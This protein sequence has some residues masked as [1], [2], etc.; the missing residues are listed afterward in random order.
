ME[1]RE[2]VHVRGVDVSTHLQQPLH[3]VL[4]A[5]GARREEHDPRR[6]LDPR[7]P[8]RRR[9][10]LVGVRFLPSLQLLGSLE[11]RR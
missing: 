9:R 5:R 2:S 3:L 6:E 4:V 7:R 10:L 11:Q 8:L 1:R